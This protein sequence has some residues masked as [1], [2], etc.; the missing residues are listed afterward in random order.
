MNC[1]HVVR[2]KGLPFPVTI[3]ACLDFSLQVAVLPQ[4]NLVDIPPCSR[5][6]SWVTDGPD[7]DLLHD[8]WTLHFVQQCCPWHKRSLNLSTDEACPNPKRLL[9]VQPGERLSILVA[10]VLV[11]CAR[12]AHLETGTGFSAP[13]YH[14]KRPVLWTEAWE[15]EWQADSRRN[16]QGKALGLGPHGL[17]IHRRDRSLT[18]ISLIL[19]S[20]WVYQ[21][22]GLLRSPR[23]VPSPRLGINEESFRLLE[24]IESLRDRRFRYSPLHSD[25]PSSDEDSNSSTEGDDYEFEALLQVG[26][27]ELAYPPLVLDVSSSDEDSNSSTGRTSPVQVRTGIRELVS[28]DLSPDLEPADDT[29]AMQEADEEAD[30]EMTYE[31]EDRDVLWINTT[32]EHR[33]VPTAWEHK[34]IWWNYF[35]K[36]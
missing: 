25:V 27:P 15:Y 5:P 19:S 10:T 33:H 26:I 9:A 13:R 36:P 22:F 1:Q 18:K 20:Q 2:H 6:A 7:E 16:G 11:A 17:V 4:G 3:D 28:E 29:T 34:K 23:I 24:Y 8:R 35:P 12:H 30:D 21:H 14:Q 31:P 32:V